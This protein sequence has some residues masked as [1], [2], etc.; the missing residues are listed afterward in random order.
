VPDNFR[1]LLDTIASERPAGFELV[2]ISAKWV[3]EQWQIKPSA[4]LRLPYVCHFVDEKTLRS[5]ICAR[6]IIAIGWRLRVEMDMS[7]RRHR[8]PA[9][10][11]RM[12]A[13]ATDTN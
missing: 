10:L 1:L 6:E 7:A 5:Q 13:A 9:R 3:P 8:D 4:R 12:P 2:A 11:Q